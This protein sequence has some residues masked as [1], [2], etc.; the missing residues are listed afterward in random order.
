M[1][2]L[3]PHHFVFWQP[4][5]GHV[6]HVGPE[7]Q[8]IPLPLIALPI[9]IA[10]GN[11]LP[12]DNAIGESVYDYLRQFPDCLFNKDYAELLQTGYAHFLADLASQVVMLDKKDVEPAYV[13]RKLT[14]LKILR[15][16]DADNTGLLWQ[17]AQGFYGLAMTF[18]ELPNVR[19]HLL[20]AMRFGQELLK[21]KGDDSAAL[22]LL[23]EVDLLFGDY[24]AAISKFHRLLDVLSGQSVA[25][26][27]QLRIDSCLE[28]GLPEHP[29]VDDLEC[30]GEAM[31]LYTTR[32]YSIAT[33]LLDRLEED[34]YFMTE[35][36]SADFFCL[37]GMCRNKN[38][39]P[40]GAFAALSQ[41]LEL[42]AG[43][44]LA[45]EVIES[46]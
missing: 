7:Q 45:R 44:E 12:D 1:N 41:A 36:R 28:I 3:D 46:I 13:F 27:I 29:L 9:K 6:I 26:K 20:E 39:D 5:V 16:L 34:D 24:P 4:P 14:Y 10:A 42:D 35:F 30:V 40:A 25:V 23:A 38:G 43:H 11:G 18:S 2:N 37:L 15:L 19:R 33:E 31:Q 17:L 8:P 32:A 22:N 21:R